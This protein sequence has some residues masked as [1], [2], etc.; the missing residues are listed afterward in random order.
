M[1]IKFCLSALLPTLVR[2]KPLLAPGCFFLTFNFL[3]F[4]CLA[5]AEQA[6]LG[7]VKSEENASQWTGITKRLQVAGVDY[8]VVDLPSVRSAADLGSRTVLFL[9]NVETLTPAQAIALEEWMSRGG[10]VI[11]SGPTG[12][13]SQPGVRQLLRSLLGAYWG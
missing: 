3:L 5:Q 7:V 4:P 11:A 6:V 10:R 12:N 1:P 8:C 9:P 13:L 2:A